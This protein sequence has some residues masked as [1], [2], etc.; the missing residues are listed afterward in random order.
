MMLA[1]KHSFDLLGDKNS[2]NIFSK[3]VF[4]KKQVPL[5]KNG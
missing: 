5:M 1:I 3:R 4:E 2:R